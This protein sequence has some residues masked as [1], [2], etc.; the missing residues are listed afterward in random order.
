[1][2]SLKTPPKDNQNPQNEGQTMQWPKEKGQ[3]DK[4]TIYKT[5]T[6]NL[7]SRSTTNVYAILYKYYCTCR[8]II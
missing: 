4:P 3:K 7:R 2:N 1:M 6:Y 5:Y 8:L